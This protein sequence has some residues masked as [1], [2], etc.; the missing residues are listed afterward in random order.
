[1][2]MAMALRTLRSASEGCL[3]LKSRCC[4]DSSGP[5]D[6]LDALDALDLAA[7]L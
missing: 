5:C 3:K 4:Q 2:R 6:D 1:M 7:W